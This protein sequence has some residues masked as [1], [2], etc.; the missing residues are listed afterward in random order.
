MHL[1]NRYVQL[2]TPQAFTRTKF[3]EIASSKQDIHASALHLLKG[4]PLNVRLSGSGDAALVKQLINMLPKP[5]L[6]APKLTLRRSAVVMSVYDDQI[7]P[8]IRPA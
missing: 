8:K 5:K 2:L 4:S 6:K 1:S 3:M 7:A